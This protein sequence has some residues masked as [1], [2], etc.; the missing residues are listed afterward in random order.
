VSASPFF[1]VGCE[2][3]LRALKWLAIMVLALVLLFWGL[4]LSTLLGKPVSSARVA[5]DAAT[6][7][8]IVLAHGVMGFGYIGQQSYW[9]DIPETLRAHGAEVRVTQVSA[10]NSSEVRGEQLMAEVARILEETGAAKV[11]LIGHS[12]GGQSVRYVAGLKPEWVASVTTVAGPTTGS[13]V[14]DWMAAR[15][16]EHPTLIALLHGAGDM[17]GQALGWLSGQPPLPQDTAATMRA[18]TRGGAAAFNQR[19]PA[20]VPTTPCGGG[21]AE[22]GGIRYYS[23]GSVGHFYRV[24]N[25]AD[26]LMSVTALAF[27][28]E[29]EN[30]GLIGRCA[31]HFGEVIRDNY[32]MN[33]FHS[34]N[35]LNGLVSRDADPVALYLEHA[36]RLKQAGL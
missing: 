12:H 19:F 25:P 7:Y 23:W 10:F 17:V 21:E 27:E 36:Q 26:Y 1:Q 31:S 2:V 13:E 16:A 20:G 9:R 5:D 32:P 4:T 15:E 14:A 34:V 30:D 3:V 29:A 6:R 22:R 24:F 35:Q 33:H 8:P 11:N 28:R 18:L